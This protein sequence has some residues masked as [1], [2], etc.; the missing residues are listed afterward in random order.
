[1]MTFKIS[2]RGFVIY[3]SFFIIT[4]SESIFIKYKGYVDVLEY[5]G[6]GILL[7]TMSIS[8]FKNKNPHEFKNL[9]LFII[10][11]LLAS[12]G[13]WQQNISFNRLF[14]L[15]FTVLA[16]CLVSICSTNY[17][18]SIKMVRGGAYAV[19]A[20]IAIS[21]FLGLIGG[22]GIVDTISN[23]LGILG[24]PIG[25]NGG[26]VYKNYYA[27]DLIII[28]ACLD[29]Y[30]KFI[31]KVKADRL[32]QRLCIVLIFLSNSRGGIILLLIYLLCSNYSKIYKL[33]SKYRKII[34][35]LFIVIG[36]FACYWIFNNV[37][38]QFSTYAYR[39]RGLINY[40]NYYEADSFHLIFGNAESFYD[41]NQNYVMAVRSTVGFD[42][43]LEMA[44]LNILIKSGILG[45]I[46][47]IIIFVRMFWLQQKVKNK[48]IS[49]GILAILITLLGSSLVEAY[50]QSI[51]CIYAVMSYLVINSLYGIDYK[52]Q[53]G[54]I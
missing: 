23:N 39:F 1:M 7:T 5:V 52:I 27:A 18:Y 17:L 43:S 28:Y 15:Q 6:Y 50:I 46:S 10:T 20:G 42:G 49:V 47:Y 30:R 14:I 25:L 44:W 53:K 12:I 4:L 40:L 33:S 41:K 38:L 8:F 51:H 3:L 32:T 31:G 36:L 48:V 34:T 24:I 35:Y 45:I 11:L 16:I 26:I 13:L 9:T 37:I 2:K 19:L 29:I 21:S 54:K 22:Y